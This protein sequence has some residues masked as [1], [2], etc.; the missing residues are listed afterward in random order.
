MRLIKSN[1][2]LLII[3]C[4]S[5][6]TSTNVEAQSVNCAP[7][8]FCSDS[9]LMTNV[10][11]AGI[12]NTSTCINSAY[13]DYTATVPAGNV[14]GGTTVPISVSVGPGGT[15]YLGVWIDY[16]HN[17]IY[18]T[19]EFTAVGSGN[20]STIHGSVFIPSSALGGVTRL[21]LRIRTGIQLA[22]TDA[23]LV[24]SYG[25]TED[26][27]LNITAAKIA[28]IYNPLFTDT[29][30][31]HSIGFTATIKQTDAA[32]I[33]TTDPLQPRVWAKAYGSGTW[34]SFKGTLTAGN[35]IN[36]TWQF[37]INHDSLGVR[38]NGCDS[39]L[40]YFVAQDLNNPVNLGYLPEPGA[41]HTSTAV[42]V[43]PAPVPF[44]YRLK[45]RLKDT[46]YVGPSNCRYQSLTGD[47]GLFQQI[48][49]RGLEG[50]LAIVIEGDIEETGKYDLKGAA[51]NG[52]SVTIRP[53]GN[54]VRA[55]IAT[56]DVVNTNRNVSSVKLNGV[57]NVTIDGSYN[58]AGR[59]LDFFNNSSY[60]YLP[61][62]INNIR[63]FN[64][65]NNITVK[66]ISFEQDR[67]GQNDGDASILIAQG[68][69]QNIS[70]FNNKFSNI[71]PDAMPQQHISSLYGNNRV[72]IRGNEFDN[73]REMA[74][75]IFTECDNWLIDSNHFY[76]TTVPSDYSY[77]WSAIYVKGGGH[78]ISNNFIGGQAPFC[79]GQ[80]LRFVDN[81]SG[82]I[83]GIRLASPGGTSAVNVIGNKIDNMYATNTLS[84]QAS[85]LT[86][87]YVL[88]NNCNI[89][90]NVIGNPQNTLPSLAAYAYAVEG[91]S[92]FGNQNTEITGNTV[93]GLT[94]VDN[95][96]GFFSSERFAGIHR[97]N[98][99]DGAHVFNA[100]SII[101]NNEITNLVNPRNP[102]E[103]NQYDDMGLT[104]GILVAGGLQNTIE[105]NRLHNFT[106]TGNVLSG[107]VYLYGAGA[108]QSV[109]Q[110]N[111]IFDLS[112]TGGGLI[113][114]IAVD[115]DTSGVQI[116]NNQVT[117]DNRNLVNGVEI[118][119]IY[120][121]Y[122]NG[123]IPKQRILYNS[124]Y[125]G[126]TASAASTAGSSVYYSRYLP[127]NDIYNNIFYNERTG[128]SGGHYAYSFT[129]NFLEQF[130]FKKAGNNLFVIPDT[131]FFARSTETIHK[132]WISWKAFTLND[133]SSFLTTPANITSSQFFTDKTQGNLNLNTANDIC[134][135]ANGKGLPENGIAGDFDNN[136]ARSTNVQSGA[137]D[138]GSDEFT[139]ST[140][141]PVLT[142]YGRHLPGGAD[143][144][145]CN[146]RI[147][148]VISWGNTGTLPVLGNCR[149]YSGD[150]PNDPTNNGTVLAARYMNA[151]WQIPVTGG[152]NYTYSITLS[153]DS[154][155]LGKVISQP[156]M[157]INKK[158]IGVP[159]TWTLVNPS[160]VNGNEHTVTGNNLSSFSEFTITDLL[161]PVPLGLTLFNGQ[162]KDNDIAL[163]WV[164]ENGVQGDRF[165]L[166]RSSEGTT[167]TEIAYMAYDA[168]Q[169]YQYT[170]TGI[171]LTKKTT[172]YYRLKMINM[173]G[174]VSYSN[175]L[176][177]IPGEGAKDFS[178]NAVYPNPFDN[179]LD[180]SISTTITQ[181]LRLR[182]INQ[183]G[184]TAYTTKRT[185]MSGN[186]IV[187]IDKVA[188]LPKGAYILQVFTGNS[189]YQYK[190]TKM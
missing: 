163:T 169:A 94:M 143:T 34:K 35:A 165:E 6:F 56:V 187:N 18:D 140:L 93:S 7:T 59:Y 100:T 120:E 139:T 155:I 101:S 33:N 166:E 121:N 45:P 180:I 61:D 176:R 46:V 22:A 112:N 164:S 150:W 66:N 30:Y 51:Q 189:S 21:R 98:N 190:I 52:H 3:F 123:I 111:R 173:S 117:L 24:Y 168:R 38:S 114:G 47:N 167:F 153:Y 109:I 161:A 126:G 188:G 26:Y 65:C 76:R 107:I 181:P 2:L 158:Q 64:S 50:D 110:R 141:P 74:I 183:Y 130:N 99:A 15:S 178:I 146:D 131:A 88:D 102:A 147:I 152:N 86:G 156:D 27:L 116:L 135:Y 154:S 49:N 12:N 23:C 53:D 79:A 9:Y 28:I 103:S 25:E 14:T 89:R 20:S 1:L 60:Y 63:I 83:A 174:S 179:N 48:N 142:V 4:L 157:I 108:A 87:V 80:P 128:G 137:T 90:N 69:N 11:F 106:V 96:S 149:W 148:A 55:V 81:P 105:Q 37:A 184:Q 85:L 77:D 72:T 127:V 97:E 42:Q 133:S 151:Y 186:N 29:L 70:I 78:T 177:F 13:G 119:G 113:N 172:L 36:G 144:L 91:I 136:T 10:S 62:T 132:G 162:E 82:I 71:T 92:S 17:G 115:W 134:W 124:I 8:S 104:S 58:G 118:R 73:F 185:I 95:T 145:S 44:G 54:T 125:V 75:H 32:G 67:S 84:A 57:N 41:V 129:G 138:I 171:L 19:N 122:N 43:T 160:T 182:I 31:N 170:D 175:I 39:I 68:T 5:F 40:Y 159:G 16:N